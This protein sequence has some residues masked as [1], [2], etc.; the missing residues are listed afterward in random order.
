VDFGGNAFSCSS[1]S[2]Q[3]L[4]GRLWREKMA[5]DAS[6]CSLHF[7]APRLIGAAQGIKAIGTLLLVMSECSFC[8]EVTHW[9][10]QLH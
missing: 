1:L 8:K 3:N 6:Q 5:V 10:L 7:V 4:A 9:L 2:A